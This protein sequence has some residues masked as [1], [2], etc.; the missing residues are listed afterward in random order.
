MSNREKIIVGLML[1]TVAYGIYAL[2]FEGKGKS[3]TTPT[4]AVSATKQLEN[5]NAF[6][7]K[8]AEASRAGLSKEDKYIISRAE[9]AWKQDPLTT[10]ELTDRPE[11][12]INR[13]KKQIIQTAGPQL[14]VS[15]TGF[16]Q[17]GDKK[18]AIID[19][20]EYTAGD[21]LVQGGFKVRSIT[22]RQVV[23]VS[24]DRSKKKFIFLIEE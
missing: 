10:V 20:L 5:L 13:Q 15:Y 12:E 7:T 1:L 21:E 9:S 3:S 2:F 18:F 19:G 11:D 8:V 22:P 23:I 14:N 4:A 6:I 24:T 17:M 16:M